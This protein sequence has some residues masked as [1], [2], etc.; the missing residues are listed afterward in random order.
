MKDLQLLTW[1]TQLGLSTAVPLI[2]VVWLA[3][4]LY[5]SCHWGAWVIVAGVILGIISAVDGLRI[6]LKSMERIT[7]DKKQNPS[8]GFN[9]HQ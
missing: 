6:S 8:V 2:G 7:K 9:D 3:V 4:W 1:L 5:R